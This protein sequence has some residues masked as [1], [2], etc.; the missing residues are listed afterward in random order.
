[1]NLYVTRH[2]EAAPLGGAVQRDADRPLTAGGEDDARL[3]A[4]ALAAL[5]G[6]FGLILSSPLERALQTSK[7]IASLLPGTPPV[8]TSGNLAPGFRPK[9][10]LAELA[11]ASSVKGVI[12]VGHQPDLGELITLLVADGSSA[13]IVFPPG[14]AAKITFDPAPGGHESGLHWLLTP[15]TV[16]RLKEKA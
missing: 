3:I 6:S 5:E 2:C 9:T 13:G 1:L 7:I 14:A 10:L 15:E 8:T 12:I 11:Q 4:G 16:R